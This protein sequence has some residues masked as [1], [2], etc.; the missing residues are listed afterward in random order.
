MRPSAANPNAI[1]LKFDATLP[2]GF[3]A[4]GIV[5]LTPLPKGTELRFKGNTDLHFAEWVLRRV[6]TTAIERGNVKLNEIAARKAARPDA[7]EGPQAPEGPTT[8]GL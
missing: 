4:D 5:T 3:H 6:L 8:P 7:P 2:R 1:E